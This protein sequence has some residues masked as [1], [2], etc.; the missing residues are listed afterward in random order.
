M[1]IGRRWNRLLISGEGLGGDGEYNAV[2]DNLSK[3]RDF[4]QF[5][6]NSVG[7]IILSC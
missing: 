7:R 2:R 5:H 4:K 1:A 3:D 6:A